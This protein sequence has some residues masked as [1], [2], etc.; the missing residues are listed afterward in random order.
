[1]SGELLWFPNQPE[2]ELRKVVLLR[3]LL[4]Q[5]GHL[6][7][8]NLGETVIA[9][10]DA[11]KQDWFYGPDGNFDRTRCLRAFVE[12]WQL[13]PAPCAYLPAAEW[14]AFF[15]LAQEELVR[16]G[17]GYAGSSDT[18]TVYR[19]CLEEH[20]PG[21]AWTTDFHTAAFFA[22][23]QKDVSGIGEIYRA[24]V[25]R[26]AVLVDFRKHFPAE[27]EVVIDPR[28]IIKVHKC[29]LT[30]D[31]KQKIAE[32]WRD[33]AYERAMAARESGMSWVSEPTLE[34][35][36]PP[37]GGW[38]PITQ[39]VDEDEPGYFEIPLTPDWLAWPA[40]GEV[41]FPDSDGDTFSAQFKSKFP[42]PPTN[43]R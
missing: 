15:T 29:V 18:V 11:V 39:C 27:Y 35:P 20:L 19:G 6:P 1:M 22:M 9:V 10:V 40:H 24:I 38:P 42:V 21:P 25:P 2:S 8:I 16:H 12:A 32:E 23:R 34:A 33:R 31:D 3:H 43:T 13:S 37:P 7:E 14:I 30:L 28:Q 4:R 36:P 5:Q 41:E 26:A 17:F